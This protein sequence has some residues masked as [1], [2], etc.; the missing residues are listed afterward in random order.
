MPM[1]LPL[2]RRS[3][4]CTDCSAS[5][6]EFQFLKIRR[7]KHLFGRERRRLMISVRSILAYG[8]CFNAEVKGSRCVSFILSRHFSR[9]VC[10]SRCWC[11]REPFR[12]GDVVGR[13]HLYRSRAPHAADDLDGDRARVHAFALTRR[14]VGR[15]NMRMRRRTRCRSRILEALGRED[16]TGASWMK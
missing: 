11:R 6:G 5:H 3:V 13:G 1:L 8:Y 9:T 16:M 12:S 10:G 7:T 2:S 15:L 4:V 14:R